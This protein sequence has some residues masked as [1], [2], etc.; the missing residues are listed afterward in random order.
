MLRNPSNAMATFALG[1]IDVAISLFTS[2][3]QHGGSTPRYHR[4]LQWLHKLRARASSKIASVSAA[5]KTFFQ[6][7]TGPD[8]RTSSED[9]EEAE[10]FELL[11][12]RTR[13]IERAGQGRP[14]ISTIH[15]DA[16]VTGSRAFND[17]HTASTQDGVNHSSGQ[18]RI[19]EN[20][21][22]IGLLSSTNPEPTD[23]IVRSTAK[24]R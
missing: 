8:Q 12:W 14:T 3:T 18:G 15:V 21:M 4:N 16:R 1:Q 17:S 13:L 22:P 24:F 7:D 20:M 11:G 19:S 23:D 9:R 5:Q 6:R 10:D 2:L